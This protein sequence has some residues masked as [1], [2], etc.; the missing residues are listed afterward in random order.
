MKKGLIPSTAKMAVE[1]TGK[2]PNGPKIRNVFGKC[3]Y[4]RLGVGF[5][6]REKPNDTGSRGLLPTGLLAQE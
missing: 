4:N 2:M 3:S 1:L 5:G 6:Q